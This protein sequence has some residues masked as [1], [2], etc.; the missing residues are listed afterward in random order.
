MYYVRIIR[1]L[2]SRCTGYCNTRLLRRC[3]EHAVEE[4]DGP[5]VPRLAAVGVPEHVHLRAPRVPYL[6]IL[7]H[8]QVSH[9]RRV[10]EVDAPQ[11]RQ[12]LVEVLPRLLNILALTPLARDVRP[13]LAK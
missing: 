11:L 3:A 2:R 5:I 13:A 1:V 7:M 9:L 12:D 10:R 4:A 6:A 8:Q